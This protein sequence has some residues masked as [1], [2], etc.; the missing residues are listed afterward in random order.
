MTHDDDMIFKSTRFGTLL[1]L[2]QAKYRCVIGWPTRGRQVSASVVQSSGEK[3]RQPSKNP[4]EE[5][6]KEEKDMQYEIRRLHR[7]TVCGPGTRTSPTH[8][9]GPAHGPPTTYLDKKQRTLAGWRP[10]KR[11]QER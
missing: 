4:T 10:A 9:A 5:N 8:S 11:R 6:K 1:D 7:H 3:A 2:Y